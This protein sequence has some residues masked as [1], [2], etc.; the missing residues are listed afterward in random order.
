MKKLQVAR[1]STGGRLKYKPSELDQN[2]ASSESSDQSSDE[3]IDS[4]ASSQPDSVS[5]IESNDED[6]LVSDYDVQ[7][8]KPA[9]TNANV[10]AEKSDASSV[11]TVPV[12]KKQTAR[13]STS[14]GM[15]VKRLGQNERYKN[16]MVDRRN[17]KKKLN[18]PTIEI[19]IAETV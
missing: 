5:T 6:K 19:D 11:E 16:K 14:A 8:E 9:E 4:F 2:D 1:K 17:L 15:L 3:S 18:E 13:K 7:Q 12:K 10:E